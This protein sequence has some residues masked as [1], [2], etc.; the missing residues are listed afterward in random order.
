MG[1]AGTGAVGMGPVVVVEGH[2]EGPAEADVR[3]PGDVQEPGGLADR[4]PDEVAVQG[5][6]EVAV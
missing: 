4:G 1:L 5:P 6:D 3:V 2:V